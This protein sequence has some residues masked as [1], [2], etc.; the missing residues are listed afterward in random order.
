MGLAVAFVAVALGARLRARGGTLEASGGVLGRLAARGRF[1]A[2]TIGHVILG[3]DSATTDALRAHERVHV[4]QYE[5]WGLLFVPAY[6]AASA[7]AWTRGR[8]PYL[9]NPFEKAAHRA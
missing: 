1:G 6:L 4:R 3:C 9:D 8:D 7:W 2:V 5:R